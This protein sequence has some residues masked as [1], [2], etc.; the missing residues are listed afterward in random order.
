[1][2]DIS[3]VLSFNRNY[4]GVQKFIKLFCIPTIRQVIH[5]ESRQQRRPS[6]MSTGSG[7]ISQSISYNQEMYYRTSNGAQLCKSC[8]SCKTC[9]PVIYNPSGMPDYPVYPPQK[10]AMSLPRQ[11]INRHVFNI[12]DFQKKTAQCLRFLVKKLLKEINHSTIQLINSNVKQ[13]SHQ[14]QCPT[15]RPVSPAVQAAQA[16]QPVRLMRTKQCNR[17]SMKNGSRPTDSNADVK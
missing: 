9:A 11:F 4:I 7:S 5:F 6:F 8:S 3:R 15:L 12:I 14:V 10:S 16:V 2:L 1:M 13:P 17:S